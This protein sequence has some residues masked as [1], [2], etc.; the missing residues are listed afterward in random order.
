MGSWANT[1]FVKADNAEAV[2]KEIETT[3]LA[4]GYKLNTAPAKSQVGP[5]WM[6]RQDEE[7]VA[8]YFGKRD[9]ASDEGSDAGQ[10]RSGRGGA[11]VLRRGESSFDDDAEFDAGE[12][13][14]DADDLDDDF[15]D[16]FD[17]DLD[18]DAYA[19]DE[20]DGGGSI[21]FGGFGD[22]EGRAIC[23]F[24]PRA[25]WVGVMD[26]SLEGN[27]DLAR[28]LSARLKTDTMLV[29]VND[30]DSWY[31]WMHRNGAEFDEFDS[32]G[33]DFDDDAAEPTG[34]W[35]EAIE[36]QDEDKLHELLMS[37]AP[38]NVKFPSADIGLPFQLANLGAKIA[39]G[40]A[41]FW[42]RLKYRWLSIKFLFKLLTGGFSEEKMDF[43]FDIP[44]AEMDD[45]TLGQHI[46]RIKTFFPAVKEEQELRELLP[47][48]RFPSE[49]LLRKYLAIVGLPW[50]YAYLSYAYLSEHSE[51]ELASHGIVQATEL[52]FD[53]PGAAA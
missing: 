38:Q 37:K 5:G 22:D 45:E 48:C 8:E 49:D 12:A 1:L 19:D 3:L 16:E 42:E 44:H 4:R 13:E 51:Q 34:E 24:E 27:I 7:L 29:L 47:K 53:P 43:G 41:T 14:F 30:S 35:L 36:S 23:I 18:V 6:A 39:T 40:Q 31:Y 2:A 26:S 46:Q 15:D 52:R 11:G 21:G 28:E 33:G 9:G 32:A 17:E 25:G 10:F 50:F 20:D